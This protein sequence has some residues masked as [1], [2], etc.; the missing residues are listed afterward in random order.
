MRE[1][2]PV[3]HIRTVMKYHH[4]CAA[5]ACIKASTPPAVR[6]LARVEDEI[7]RRVFNTNAV[8][9]RR[10]ALLGIARYVK[11]LKHRCYSV[12]AFDA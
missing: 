1:P 11:E 3:C 6:A 12:E 8:G 9:E 10:T 2:C 7:H 5:P 4:V